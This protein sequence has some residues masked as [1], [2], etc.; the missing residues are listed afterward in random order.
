M[1]QSQFENIHQEQ[2]ASFTRL[3]EGLEK[4]KKKKSFPEMTYADFPN[5]YRQ[6]CNHYGVAQVRHYSPALV[7]RLHNLVLRGHRQ[8]YRSK[9]G[10][11]WS[12]IRFIGH[13]FPQTLRDHYRLFWLAFLLFFGPAVVMGIVTYVDPSLTYSLMGEEQVVNIESM[14]HPNNKL[15]GRPLDRKAE[16]DLTMFGYYI[17]NNISIGFRTFAGGIAFGVGTVFFLVFNGLMIGGVAGHLSHPPYNTTFWPFVC[18]HGPFELTAIV[19]SGA[20]GLLLGYSLIRPGRYRRI[21]S[22]KMQAPTALK[23]VLGAAVM[24]LIAAAFEAFWSSSSLTTEVKYG[25]AGLNAIAVILYLYLAG[26]R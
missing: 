11:L 25:V 24:L 6:L 8:L 22:L 5:Q 19:I 1:N 14:Y 9:S 4:K 16:T 3:L 10:L 12:I 21:D 23:L 26:R 20:A 18:G 17:L 15:N 7:D 13:D 2:W